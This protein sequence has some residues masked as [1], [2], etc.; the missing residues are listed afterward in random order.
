MERLGLVPMLRSSKTKNIAVIENK[1][2]LSKHYLD[3]LSTEYNIVE[4]TTI[5]T[6]TPDLIVVIGGDG[7]MLHSIHH[8]MDLN[9]PFYGIKTGNLGFLMNDIN[10][11]ELTPK[12]LKHSI[13]SAKEISIRPLEM[14][15]TDLKQKHHKALAVNEVALLRQTHQTAKVEIYVNGKLQ[16]K[17]LTSDGIMVATPAGSTAYNLS[18]GG[19]ILPI[20]ANLLALTPISPFRP[21][22]WHGALVDSESE[23]IIEVIDP[24]KRSVSAT[25]DF[26]EVRDIKTVSIK[27][28]NQPIR[29]LFDPQQSFEERTLR[30]Q[31]VGVQ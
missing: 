7:M 26:Y 4:L 22:R 5:R 29:L 12:N 14:D 23:I 2:K 1:T 9:I 21:R 31:F 20:S 3:L 6:Q 28:A 10:H 25:A 18:A 24:I 27:I 15:A 13:S 30:E 16:L 19:P 8:Y 17:N 11:P